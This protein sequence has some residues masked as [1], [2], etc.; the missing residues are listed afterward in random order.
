MELRGHTENVEDI[1]FHPNSENELCSSS[2]DQT[3]LFWDTRS[4][5]KPTLK[6]DEIHSDDINCVDWNPHNSNLLLAGSS[7]HSVSVI[8]IRNS[9][10]INYFDQHQ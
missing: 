6:I 9:K 4:G 3:I 7:D 5:S 10:C 8:D 1:C 2:Q